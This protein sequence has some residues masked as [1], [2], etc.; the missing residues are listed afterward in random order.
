[1][2]PSLPLHA[3]LSCNL[4]LKL[5][6]VLENHFIRGNSYLGSI[7]KLACSIEKNAPFLLICKNLVFS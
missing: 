6:I 7:L 2:F 5:L 3:L 4:V 1:M